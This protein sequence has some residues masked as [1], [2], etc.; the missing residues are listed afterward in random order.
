MDVPELAMV[1]AMAENNIIGR[2]GGLPW[3][4]S[5]DLRRFKDLTMGKPIVMGRRT[6]DSLGRVLPGRRHVVVSRQADFGA[7]GVEAA[8]SLDEAL[9]AAHRAA[10]EAGA[11]QICVIGGGQI[12]AQALPRADRLYVTHVEAVVEGDTCFPAI[13]DALWAVVREERLPADERNTYATRFVEYR[14][15]GR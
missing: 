9:S 13:D 10:R 12:Y 8:G 2:D 14:R 7:E 5:A 3:R 4:L 1:V 15:I 11:S 6:W